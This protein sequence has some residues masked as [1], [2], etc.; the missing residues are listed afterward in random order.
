MSFQCQAS[1][2][3]KGRQRRSIY[4]VDANEQKTR[5]SMCP[6]EHRPKRRQKC[7]GRPCGFTTCAEVGRPFRAVRFWN[8]WIHYLC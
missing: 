4:C 6:K 7:T 3:Q 8:M 2:G 5:R 1:C